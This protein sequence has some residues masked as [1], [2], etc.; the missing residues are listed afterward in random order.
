MSC[1]Y[2]LAARSS[3]K[4]GSNVQH[5]N[6]QKKLDQPQYVR[7]RMREIVEEDTLPFFFFTNKPTGFFAISSLPRCVELGRALLPQ[8]QCVSSQVLATRAS[9]PFLGSLEAP[10]MADGPGATP[11]A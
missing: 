3:D 2:I 11:W 6:N 10:P 4:D 5:T 1:K 9:C 7:K 8:A